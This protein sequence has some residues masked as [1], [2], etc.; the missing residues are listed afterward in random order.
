MGLAAAAISARIFWQSF[1]CLVSLR[2]IVPPSVGDAVQRRRVRTEETHAH[3]QLHT[4]LVNAITC[5]GREQSPHADLLC[6][7]AETFLGWIGTQKN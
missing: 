4:Q 1:F 5:A 6:W 7:G 3:A 2:M